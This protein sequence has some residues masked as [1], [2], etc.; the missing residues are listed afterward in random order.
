MVRLYMRRQF[1][2][3]ATTEKTASAQ[4]PLPAPRRELS[5]KSHD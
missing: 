2:K 1:R 4:P 3:V 5:G